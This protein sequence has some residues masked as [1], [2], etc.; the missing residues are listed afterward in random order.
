MKNRYDIKHVTNV[1]VLLR[2]VVM[3]PLRRGEANA[4]TG[5]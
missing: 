2:V 5:S 3:L 1:V 4:Q